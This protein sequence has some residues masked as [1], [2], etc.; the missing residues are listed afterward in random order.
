MHL[1][2]AATL[3]GASA[4]AGCRISSVSG[5]DP[6]EEDFKRNVDLTD[7]QVA[8]LL[9]EFEQ[10]D[11]A[12]LQ[13]DDVCQ[14]IYSADNKLNTEPQGFEVKTCKLEI[15]ERSDAPDKVI[16]SLACE[17][18]ALAYYCEGR[19]PLGHVER[20]PAGTDLPAF[21]A[22]C[23]TLEAASVLAFDQLADRLAAWSA[24]ALLVARC[25]R[26][27]ADEAVHAHLLTALAHRRGATVEPPIQRELPVDLA[28]AALD[29]AVEGCVH[30]AWS[31][32][33]CAVTA[34]DSHDP[35]LRAIYTRLA[36]DEAGHAQ[37]A[38]DL[39]TWFLAQL[40]ADQR[41]SVTA[42]QHAAITGLPRLADAQARTAPALLAR[43]GARLAARFAAGLAR[44]A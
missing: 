8:A 15:R 35:E 44:A 22:H 2:I 37:L 33:T 12:A 36:A 1:L 4:S 13:C 16:G 28:A 11:P 30:E 10:T 6:P 41:A 40:S 32:L 25:R 29:N 42:A 27:A 39:H 3:A 34:R 43:Q 18:H 26:A 21:L 14:S 20:P 31:A 38:W 7:A 19:R 5:C 9:T 23:A 24:P 17:G